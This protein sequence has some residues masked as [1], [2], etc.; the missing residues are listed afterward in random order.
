MGNGPITTHKTIFYYKN[1]IFGFVYFRNLFYNKG[2]LAISI[3]KVG[4]IKFHVSEQITFIRLAIL[5]TMH[6]LRSCFFRSLLLFYY[7]P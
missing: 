3:T 6:K 7:P 1:T 5:L 4:E 2:F